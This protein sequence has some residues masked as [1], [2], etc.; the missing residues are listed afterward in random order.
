MNM[1]AM[2]FVPGDSERKLARALDSGADALILDLEDSVAPENKA[3]ARAI[4]RTALDAPRTCGAWVRI[5]ALD[6]GDALADLAAVVGGRPDGVVLPKACG[7]AD[8]HRLDHY[9]SALEAREAL[10][11]GSLRVLVVATETGPSMFGIGTY[12]PATPR[13]A[14]L[15]WGAEDLAADVGATSNADEA[16]VLTPLYQLARSL[17]LAASAAAGVAAIDTAFMGLDDEAGLMRTCREARRDGFLGKLAI[18]PAQ[19]PVILEGFR[20]TAAEIEHA[21]RVVAAFA[22]EPTG[23]ARLDGKM[24]DIPHLKQAR[25]LL[26]MSGDGQ[27]APPLFLNAGLS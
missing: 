15:T 27:L 2:L 24:I 26:A 3:R 19:V 9:L 1:R 11:S 12:S 4:V 10:P 13:L 7:D 25:R 18:H 17:C 5:N 14:G 20:P 21:R 16:G 8:V 22:A 23:V 6:T